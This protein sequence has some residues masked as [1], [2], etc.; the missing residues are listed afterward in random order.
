MKISM[1]IGFSKKL[2]LARCARRPTTPR[3]MMWRATGTVI[4]RLEKM[5][6]TDSG[7]EDLLGFLSKFDFDTRFLK[8]HGIEAVSDLATSHSNWA[9]IISISR[10]KFSFSERQEEGSCRRRSR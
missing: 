4:R 2:P 6:F 9:K 3:L 1:I 8:N 7:F 5:D 10:L